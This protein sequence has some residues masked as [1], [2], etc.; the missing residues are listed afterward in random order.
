M[1]VQGLQGSEMFFVQ[2][3]RLQMRSSKSN[4]DVKRLLNASL[5]YAQR[6][7]I[8]KHNI[9]ENSVGAWRKRGWLEL[10]KDMA[11]PV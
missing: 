11:V 6:M 4:K 1:F 10:M 9:F 8:A 5:H 3:G 2:Q 7:R